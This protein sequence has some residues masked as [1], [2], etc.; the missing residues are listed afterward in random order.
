MKC[1]AGARRLDCKCVDRLVQMRGPG[2]SYSD[3]ILRLVR[4]I[5]YRPQRPSDEKTTKPLAI[6]R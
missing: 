3:V 6:A 1:H 5:S 4:A 2:Q